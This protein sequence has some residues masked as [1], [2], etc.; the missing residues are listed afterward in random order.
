MDELPTLSAVAGRLFDTLIIEKKFSSN[1]PSDQFLMV[2][3]LRV[4]FSICILKYLV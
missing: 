2:I 3:K 4:I 1:L